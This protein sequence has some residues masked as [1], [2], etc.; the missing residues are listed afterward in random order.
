MRLH[1]IPQQ[2]KSRATNIS[3]LIKNFFKKNLILL[4]Y[5]YI[6]TKKKPQTKP[7]QLQKRHFR[8]FMKDIQD[9]IY[10]ENTDFID[11]ML[12]ALKSIECRTEPHLH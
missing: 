6:H 12:K 7:K 5:R 9:F 8:N 1:C 2:I 10:V 4:L 11:I 3:K